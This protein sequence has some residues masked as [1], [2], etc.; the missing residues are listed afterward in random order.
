MDNILCEVDQ[1]G[2]KFLAHGPSVLSDTEVLA[3]I[4]QP[5]G[6]TDKHVEIARRI[7]QDNNNNLKRVSQLTTNELSR[8][9]GIGTA[10][11]LQIRAAMEFGKRSRTQQIKMRQITRSEHAYEEFASI[12]EGLAIEKFAIHIL[13]RSNRILTTQVISMGGIHGTVVDPKV[14]FKVALDWGGSSIILGHNHP[15]GQ[16]L[17]SEADI[18]LTK[19]LVNAGKMLEISIMDHI[20]YCDNRY[21][22]FADEGRI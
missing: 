12:F 9:R 20:I 8:Y 4:I 13:N 16:C 3:M 14:L 6:K 1:P 7:L 17:P 15:S 10:T 11:A 5:Q 2:Y 21:Y 22:S 19:K 18:E